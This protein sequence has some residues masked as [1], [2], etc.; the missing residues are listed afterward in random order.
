M[1]MQIPKC[2]YHTYIHNIDISNLKTRSIGNGGAIYVHLKLPS[3]YN[4]IGLVN[5]SNCVFKANHSPLRGGVI[6]VNPDISLHV[7]R[8]HFTSIE[9]EGQHAKVPIYIFI[10]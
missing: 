7:E 1:P 2:T 6:F 8:S 5:V 4:S 9:S 10:S 3:V